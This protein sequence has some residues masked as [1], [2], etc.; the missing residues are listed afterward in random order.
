[1]EE[2][3]KEHFGLSLIRKIGTY[4]GAHRIQKYLLLLG[5][6]LLTTALFT[7]ATFDYFIHTPK[8]KA[9][10]EQLFTV[11]NGQ[12]LRVI[13]ENLKNSN[14]ISSDLMFMIYLKLSGLSGTIKAGEYDIS[15]SMPPVEI[16]DILTKGRV[17]SKTITIPEGWTIAQIGSYLEQNGIV[18]K[19]SFVAATKDVYDY[20]FLEKKPA[21]LSLEGFLFPDTYQVSVTSTPRSLVVMMLDNF[22][23]RVTPE[24]RAAAANSGIGLY[25]ALTL[26]SVVEKEANKPA[27]RKIVA[28]IFVSRLNEGMRLQSDVTVAYGVGEDK[29]ELTAADLQTESPYNTYLVDGLPVGPIC[30]PGVESINAVL[31]PEL[32]D[33]RYFIAAN[34]QMFYA[35][36]LDEH[37]IN[38]AKYLP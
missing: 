7:L 25:G 3:T 11:Q 9:A 20:D 22:G 34:E 33:F 35:K 19:D 1:M 31:Y 37:N 23:R 5:F 16:A 4:L 14:L 18:T 6:V 2:R 28:G 27:D 10:S 29:K 13:S 12:G 8:Q 30:N 17:T 24:M 15:P 36:T 32:T 38:V 26:A 21:E